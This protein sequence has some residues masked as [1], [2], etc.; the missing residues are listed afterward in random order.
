MPDLPTPVQAY[1]HERLLALRAPAYLLIR[2]D[3][4]LDAWEGDLALYGMTDL[5]PGSAI[6]QQ[7]PGLAGLFPFD[8]T[9][10]YIPCIETAPGLFADFHIFP[11]DVGA[12]VLL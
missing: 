3:G 1:V 4:R 8:G 10:L 7:I 11:A 9:P 5:Q 6:E 12:W 2:P